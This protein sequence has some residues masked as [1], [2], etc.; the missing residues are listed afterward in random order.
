MPLLLLKQLIYS[1]MTLSDLQL[2][3]LNFKG[4]L[5]LYFI[6]K[7]ATG[8]GSIQF[9]ASIQI[10]PSMFSLASPWSINFPLISS[11]AKK[12]KMCYFDQLSQH[13][14]VSSSQFKS[15]LQGLFGRSVDQTLTTG[16]GNQ[17]PRTGWERKDPAT[18]GIIHSII[19]GLADDV[20]VE[21]NRI[22]SGPFLVATALPSI[23]GFK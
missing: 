8:S 21:E 12:N 11:Q 5:S 16:Q 15:G 7:G 10:L 17:S 13:H 6:T 23:S 18:L 20:Y 2:I 4:S 22:Q 19:Q 9:F 3:S 14:V 1:T